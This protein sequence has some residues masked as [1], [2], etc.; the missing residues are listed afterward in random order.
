MKSKLLKGI[1]GKIAVGYAIII[2]VTLVISFSTF[3]IVKSLRNTDKELSESIIQSFLILKEFKSL[4]SISF[5]LTSNWIYQ[6]SQQ[7]KE[8]LKTLIEKDYPTQ[9]TK[10][11]AIIEASKSKSE[12]A[13]ALLKKME[14]IIEMEKEVT[15]KLSADSFYNNDVA[16]D[17]AIT[18]L[19]G[20]IKPA[21]EEF[22]KDVD[23]LIELQQ[24]ALDEANE[25]K[26]SSYSLLTLTVVIST[27]VYAIVGVIASLVSVKAIVNPINALKEIVLNLSQGKINEITIKTKHDEV[28]EIVGAIDKLVEGIKSNTSFAIHIGEG[29]Y[30]SSFQPLSKEDQ[31]GNA[32]LQMRSNLKR[33]SEEDA[34]RNWATT[35]LAETGEI[36][37]R[38]DQSSEMLYD[39]IILFLVKYLKANQGGLFVLEDTNPEDIHLRMVGCYA[40]NRKKFI[41]QRIDLGQGLIGQCYLEKEIIYMTKVPENYARITS[42][43]GEATPGCVLIVP[44]KVNDQIQGVAEIACFK[45]FEKH[46]I[47]FVSKLAESIASSIASVKINTRTQLLLHS[48]QQQAE[49]LK[50]QEE[51]MRQNMEELS[52]TQ[53][54][55]SRRQ[56]D[57]ENVIKAIDSSFAVVEFEPTGIILNTNQN[58]ATLMGYSLSEMKGRHHRMFVDDETK[59]SSE[60]LAF[61]NKLASGIELKG[62]FKRVNKHGE[63]VWINGNY[64]PMRDK[65]GEVVKIM[66]V[67]FDLTATKQNEMKLMNEITKLQN[68]LGVTG[69]SSTNKD[70]VVNRVIE[71]LLDS[72]SHT[73]QKMD[74]SQVANSFEKVEN[75]SSK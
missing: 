18:L 55:I 66:K 50:A 17:E 64:T 38:T 28:G 14:A 19:S 53:E 10:F 43:L 47:D 44:L 67:A 1:A 24:K 21:V 48:S 2:G 7:D 32:L 25:K 27:L 51:E 16:V 49:E 22:S 61:W 29:N 58:F 36:L 60:Y 13:T 68:Q 9:A 26:V 3:F 11:T 71:Q 57:N 65:T 63:P 54:E 31:M 73:H 39:Q 56:L 12:K 75:K 8:S 5:R 23:E 72:S 52:A 45:S 41:D 33:S 6:P 34:K 30:D 46:E 69:T 74:Y 42:G 59:E 4:N 40:Y 15:K 35:G 37:R 62:N 20:K 70:D